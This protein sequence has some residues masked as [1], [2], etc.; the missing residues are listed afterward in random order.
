MSMLTEA[1]RQRLQKLAGIDT[2]LNDAF[3]V[4]FGSSKA[5]T[6]SGEPQVVHHGTASKFRKFNPKKA[7]M[8]G[9]FWFTS[10]KGAIERGEIGAQGRGHV[11]DLYVSIQNPAGW[12]EYEKLGLWELKSRGYDGAILPNK[13]GSFDGFVFDP[14]QLK[15]V[16]NDG[17]WDLD[18]DN[19]RS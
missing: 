6:A 5:V 10:N 18:D 4:W 2:N 16:A 3:R 17:S 15:S 14:N 19:I 11:M 9:I 12:A 13:D 1:Q 7:T 8:G